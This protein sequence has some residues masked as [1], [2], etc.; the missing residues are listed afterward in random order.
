MYFH[1]N[2]IYENK[3]VEKKQNFVSDYQN[4]L[5]GNIF[6]L[7][8]IC[9]VLWSICSYV[10]AF[11]FKQILLTTKFFYLFFFFISINFL[12]KK[13]NLQ[14]KHDAFQRKLLNK[15]YLEM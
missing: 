15:L 12:S 11:N 3:Y 10:E 6:F 1:N 8:L 7:F 2:S 4:L 14:Q 9:L 13:I 5:I